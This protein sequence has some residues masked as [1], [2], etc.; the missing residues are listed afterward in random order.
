MARSRPTR[1][2]VQSILL[3]LVA[4]RNWLKMEGVMAVMAAEAEEVKVME[5]MEVM[6]VKAAAARHKLGYS[7][8]SYRK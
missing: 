8:C 4:E 1:L 3:E 2:S 6:E 5:V 7:L